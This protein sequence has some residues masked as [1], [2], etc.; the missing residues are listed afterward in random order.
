MSMPRCLGIYYLRLIMKDK[1]SSL[2]VFLSDLTNVKV[3]L[4]LQ[5]G[6]TLVR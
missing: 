5:V 4:K 6:V 3:N 1:I 2:F